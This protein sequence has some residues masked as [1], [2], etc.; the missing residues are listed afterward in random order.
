MKYMLRDDSEG[1]AS[2]VATM[3]TLVVIL[4]ILQTQVIG[5]VPAKQYEAEHITSM[6]AAAAFDLLRSTSAGAAIPNGRFTVTIPV[7]TPPVSPF[8]VA[9]EGLLQFDNTDV[10]HATISYR[11]E[12][13]VQQGHVTKTA[14]DIILAIDSSGSMTW[15]DPQNLRLTGAR[16]YIGRL[17]FPDR[18][19]S[20]D[21]DDNA[22]LTRANV[23]QQAFHLW[24][25]GNDGI[26]DYSRPQSDISTIDSNG[27][28]NFGG[29]LQVSNNELIAN[30]KPSHAWVVILLTDGQNNFAWEDALAVSEANRAKANGITLFTIGLGPD[31]DATL[32]TQIATITGGTYYSAPTASSIRWIYYDISMR[33]TGFIQCGTLTAANT[34]SGTLTLNL[35]SRRYPAQTLR[36]EAGGIA[37]TQPDGTFVQEGIP[38]SFAPSGLGTGALRLTL[39][40]YTGDAFKAAGSDYRFVTAQFV[41]Q[42]IEQ[43]FIDRP[44]LGAERAAASNISAYVLYWAQQGAATIPA[45]QAVQ[46]PMNSAASNLLWGKTNMSAAKPIL[47]KSNVANARTYLATAGTVADQQVTNGIMQKWLA[48][49]IKQQIGQLNCRLDQ[50]QNWYDGIT[51]TFKSPNTKAWALWFNQTFLNAGVP[52]TYGTSGSQVVLSVN[53]IDHL[54][55]DERVIK[56]TFS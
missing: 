9:S 53:A 49:S 26:P 14:Q 42:N 43:Q 44:D 47:A 30:G 48:V 18:V 32:L 40:T 8:A 12:P 50:W 16:E 37:V 15:N 52:F 33:Y 3:F 38:F 36:L 28:T 39:L 5:A 34:I 13:S 45:A 55:L 10:A 6:N 11:F 35:G 51:M 41:K 29:A 7:G 54:I 21:F 2:T 25:Q 23:G 20:V 4:I 56:L 27:G 24:S 17:T 46:G 19:A 1:V 31:A 22:A